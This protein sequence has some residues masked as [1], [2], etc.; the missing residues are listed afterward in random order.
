MYFK[1]FNVGLHLYRTPK[2]HFDRNSGRAT[3]LGLKQLKCRTHFPCRHVTTLP[4]PK[5]LMNIMNSVLKFKDKGAHAHPM[6]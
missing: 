4:V 5:D 6:S 3:S 1:S 2:F